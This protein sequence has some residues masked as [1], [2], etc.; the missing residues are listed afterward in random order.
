[1]EHLIPS[2]LCKFVKYCA[3]SGIHFSES[4]KNTMH[5]ILTN[6]L[7]MIYFILSCE[8]IVYFYIFGQPFLLFLILPIIAAFMLV[9]I[10]NRYGHQ[11]AASISF[12]FFT[13]VGIYLFTSIIGPDCGIQATYFS[14][15]VISSLLFTSTQTKIRNIMILIV[16]LFFIL[17]E[18]TNYHF[19]FFIDLPEYQL[20]FIRISIIFNL[21]IILYFLVQFQSEMSNHMSSKLNHMTQIYGLT[22]RE[23]EILFLLCQGLINTQ[24]SEK[25]NIS[26]ST[27]KTHFNNIYKKLNISNRTELIAF[28]YS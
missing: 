3:H 24:I 5:I 22:Q 2:W 28:F 10:I 23:T 17:S 27:V 25:L 7:A 1:M 18:L 4:Y 13:C 15:F 8:Y 6:K 21:F 26:E 9:I 11:L 19:F 20:K 14:L 16:S 12:I